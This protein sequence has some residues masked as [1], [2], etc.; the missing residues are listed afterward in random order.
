MRDDEEQGRVSDSEPETR[1]PRTRVR[2]KP[3]EGKVTPRKIS[4]PDSLYQ[5]LEL[6]AVEKRSNVSAVA[7]ELLNRHAYS[8]DLIRKS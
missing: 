4:M 2:K 6:M 1:V 5:R 8:Y 7:V 3:P